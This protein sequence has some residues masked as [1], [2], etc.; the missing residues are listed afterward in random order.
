M[1]FDKLRS[2]V[3]SS[4]KEVTVNTTELVTYL[5][6]IPPLN[7]NELSSSYR[8]RFVRG[9]IVNINYY[10]NRNISM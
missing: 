3:A 8:I 4:V 5:E 1:E 10:K 9:L 7:P 2:L 6:D